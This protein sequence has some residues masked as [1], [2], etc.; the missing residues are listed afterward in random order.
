MKNS[1]CLV[2]LVTSSF[3]AWAQAHPN[4]TLC[5]ND[6]RTV[7]SCQAG[8]K[9][10]S[11]CA[12]G[13]FSNNTGALSY[14]FGKYGQVPEL[15]Y[16]STSATVKNRFRY[17]EESWAKGMITSVKFDSGQFSYEVVHARGAFGVDGGPNRAGVNVLRGATRLT[18]VAC[19]EKHAVDRMYEELSATSLHVQP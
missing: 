2:L 8:L 13:N 19:D 11:I 14:R 16:K 3:S 10:V 1:L 15:I 12:T 7:F 9:T 4:G 5:L 6:E 18:E 17:E